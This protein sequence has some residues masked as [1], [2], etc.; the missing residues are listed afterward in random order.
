AL[1]LVGSLGASAPA[2][3]QDVV[4]NRESPASDAGAASRSNGG[5][6]G[7][8]LKEESAPGSNYGHLKFP[9]I[10]EETLGS[11]HP[12]L[13]DASSG[14]IIDFYGPLDH[15]P[16]GADEVRSQRFQLRHGP[17]E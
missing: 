10:R 12:V 5:A 1:L 2:D 13:K 16:L 6:D 7:I 9:A 15:D 4:S 3:A 8:L 17:D 11:D 14:D